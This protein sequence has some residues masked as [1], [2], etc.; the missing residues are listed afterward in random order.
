MKKQK[1]N[2]TWNKERGTKDLEIGKRKGGIGGLKPYKEIR[3]E[4]D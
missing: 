3:I 4:I 1:N 2:K